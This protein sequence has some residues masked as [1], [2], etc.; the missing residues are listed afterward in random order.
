MKGAQVACFLLGTVCHISSR[1]KEV[2]GGDKAHFDL[3]WEIVGDNLF[4]IS[5][6][7]SLNM[8]SDFFIDKS[9]LQLF[10]AC[11]CRRAIFNFGFNMKKLEK[12]GIE[13]AISGNMENP[14]EVF[15]INLL[16]LLLAKRWSGSFELFLF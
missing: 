2:F 8:V 16:D 3:S 11:S 4:C 7:P 15:E 5:E 14:R 12:R 6:E 10:L 1:T 13:Y 9:V